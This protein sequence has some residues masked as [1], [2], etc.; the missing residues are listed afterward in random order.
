MEIVLTHTVTYVLLSWVFCDSFTA[1]LSGSYKRSHYIILRILKPAPDSAPRFSGRG[2][3]ERCRV[4]HTVI[5]HGF[6]LFPA[7]VEAELSGPC[8]TRTPSG[9]AHNRP[10]P[11]LTFGAH[12]DINRSRATGSAARPPLRDRAR[13]APH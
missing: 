1:E 7:P 8:G 3:E 5:C 6:D 10:A 13:T 9:A 4:W 12:L 11:A 2:R